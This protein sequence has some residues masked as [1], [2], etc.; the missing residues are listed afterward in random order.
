MSKCIEIR[1]VVI[2]FIAATT[3]RLYNIRNNTYF[4]I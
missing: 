2:I 1:P 3:I 4:L